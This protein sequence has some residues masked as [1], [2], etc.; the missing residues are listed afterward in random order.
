VPISNELFDGR[1]PEGTYFALYCHS[2]GSSGYVQMQ[3]KPQ[4]PQHHFINIAGG[5]GMYGLR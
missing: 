4:L 2:G 5:I 1:Y 3:L